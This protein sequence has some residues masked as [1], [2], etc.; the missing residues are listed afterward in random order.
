MPARTATLKKL[1]LPAIAAIAIAAP[2][3]YASAQTSPRENVGRINE[4]IRELKPS[5]PAQRSNRSYRKRIQRIEIPRSQARGLS[6]PYQDYVINYNHTLDLTV[7][8]HY[9]SAE[10]TPK[11][12]YLLDT[13]GEALTSPELSG[14]RYLIAGHTDAAGSRAYNQDLSA[15]RAI[16]VA[17]YLV[18]EFGIDPERLIPVGFGEE[19]LQNERDPYSHRNRRVE[20]ALI[21]DELDYAP[22]SSYRLPSKNYLIDED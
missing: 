8:F 5:A 16:A 7:Y 10:I 6:S 3:G 17:R 13:L 19:R 12:S 11:A 9:D 15:R 18:N 22:E 1:L 2:L 14:F 20:V 4:M 21:E